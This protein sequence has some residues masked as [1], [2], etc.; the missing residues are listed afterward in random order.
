MASPTRNLGEIVPQ[1]TEI[2][3]KYCR[4][5]GV[6]FL[7]NRKLKFSRP[8]DFDDPFELRPQP[9][10]AT[11]SIENSNVL[12]RDDIRMMDMYNSHSPEIPF[13]DWLRP[14]RE[15]P[16]E[17]NHELA[18]IICEGIELFCSTALETIS[19]Q[20]GMTCFSETPSDVRMWSHYGDE[21]KGVVVGLDRSLLGINLLPVQCKRE[22][23][24][25]T[26][27]QFANPQVEWA[28]KLLTTKS[29]DWAYQ[30]EWRAV[31]RFGEAPLE[32]D[33]QLGHIFQVP[34]ESV[35]RV[36]IG[37]K[38][39]STTSADIQDILREVYPSIVPE[40][41]RPHRSRFAMEFVPVS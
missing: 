20:Y 13:E 14:R 32:F 10:D 4:K 26:A 33:N 21:H 16:T 25:Y 22:R 8:I 1:S 7:E 19:E 35:K 31:L 17:F 41:A 40:I 11:L 23:V 12:L 36:L 30:K 15:S 29:E 37:C 18:R 34:M 5:Y 6:G 9:G 3:Y 38:A 2:I 27:S 39:H 28:V 24:H